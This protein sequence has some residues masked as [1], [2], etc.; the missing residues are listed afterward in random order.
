MKPLMNLL[1]FGSAPAGVSSTP[2]APVAGDQ[3]VPGA[4]APGTGQYLGTDGKVYADSSY[5]TGAG[6]SGTS[7]HPDYGPATGTD[8]DGVPIYT[9]SNGF[10]VYGDGSSVADMMGVDNTLLYNSPLS[11]GYVYEDQSPYGSDWNTA[12]AD[13][14][15][16]WY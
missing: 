6:G 13:S 1:G 12:A 9:D 15:D 7:T 14:D 3:V 4:T 11:G 5:G 2:I 10:P 16:S 8:A